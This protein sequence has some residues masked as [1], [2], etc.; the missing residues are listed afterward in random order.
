[1]WHSI[2]ECEDK[3]ILYFWGDDSCLIVIVLNV[4][5]M[6]QVGFW[7]FFEISICVLTRWELLKMWT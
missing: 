4:K 5:V 1:M 7:F 2:C 6:E 3:T